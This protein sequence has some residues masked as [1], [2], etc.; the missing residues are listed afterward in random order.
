MCVCEVGYG[1]GCRYT[2]RDGWDFEREK[3]EVVECAVGE[4]CIFWVNEEG[5]D[6]REIRMGKSSEDG[7][8]LKKWV[9]ELK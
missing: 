4:V 6:F 3:I 2:I 7:V 9:E 1:G 8:V 5:D